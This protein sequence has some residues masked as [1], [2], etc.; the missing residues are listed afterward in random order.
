MGRGDPET[1]YE[2]IAYINSRPP[3]EDQILIVL[4]DSS[5][6]VTSAE[7][8]SASSTYWRGEIPGLLRLRRFCSMLKFAV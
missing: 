3:A 1:K 5:D 7:T 4:S 6:L 2:N 8:V